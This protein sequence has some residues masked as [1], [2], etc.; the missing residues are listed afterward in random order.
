YDRIGIASGAAQEPALYARASASVIPQC[1]HPVGM[2][3][4]RAQERDRGAE[5]GIRKLPRQ[6]S[7][8]AHC[9]HRVQML[10]EFIARQNQLVAGVPYAAMVTAVTAEPI[11]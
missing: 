11:Q 2:V 4:C 10:R 7:P 1:A 8:A 6:R 9:G 3:K 5:H